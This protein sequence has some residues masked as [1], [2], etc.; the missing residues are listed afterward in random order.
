M[1]LSSLALGVLVASC[2]LATSASKTAAICADGEVPQTWQLRSAPHNARDLRE[3]ADPQ[4]KY[5][6]HLRDRSALWLESAGG[7]LMLCL[8][9]GTPRYGRSVT[10]FSKNQSGEYQVSQKW[11]VIRVD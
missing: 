1:R 2:S 6:E 10:V 7:D 9:S 3:V 11:E 8:F 4:D 5:Y